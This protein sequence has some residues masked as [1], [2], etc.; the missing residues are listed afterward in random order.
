[1]NHRRSRF[2]I[3]GDNNDESNGELEAKATEVIQSVQ[4][5]E[6]AAET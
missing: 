6:D 5:R 3:K 4:Q 2:K 1:M